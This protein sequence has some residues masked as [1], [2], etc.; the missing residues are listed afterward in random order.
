M[1][2]FIGIS[3]SQSDLDPRSQDSNSNISDN[4][5]HNLFIFSQNQPR[6]ENRNLQFEGNKLVVEEFLRNLSTQK[7]YQSSIIKSFEEF[8]QNQM[9]KEIKRKLKVKVKNQN[10]SSKYKLNL[11]QSNLI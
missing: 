11:F 6:G 1:V 9:K 4:F 2:I 7:D 8:Y 5:Y 3:I 10:I